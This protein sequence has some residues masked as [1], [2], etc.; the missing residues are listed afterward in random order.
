ME[1][2]RVRQI[3]F[4]VLCLY[5]CAVGGFTLY[6]QTGYIANLP[7]AR[8]A[9]PAEREIPY[10]LHAQATVKGGQLVC[11]V[12]YGSGVPGEVIL[13]G[14]EGD[15]TEDGET[16]GKAVVDRQEGTVYER[17]GVTFYFTI[18]TG[19]LQE[20]DTVEVAVAGETKTYPGA[21]PRTA[22]HFNKRNEACL[23]TIEAQQGPWGPR[24]VLQERAVGTVWPPQ[25][26]SMYV[27]LSASTGKAPIVV[28]LASDRPYVGMEVRLVE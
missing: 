6:S 5:L 26:D 10:E 14:Q 18:T 25:N 16:V 23:Y 9:R 4:A 7:S 8:L 11:H 20:G 28:E 24:F 27:L 1:K 13:P 21:V 17:T 12:P 3:L 22:V 2:K 19:R 15:I